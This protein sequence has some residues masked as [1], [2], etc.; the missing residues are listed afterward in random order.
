MGFLGEEPK[1]LSVSEQT[2]PRQVIDRYQDL[3]EAARPLSRRR[4][5]VS[6]RV[7]EAEP[8]SRR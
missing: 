5:F 7:E 8:R 2:C 1:R 6:V 4:Q 3:D